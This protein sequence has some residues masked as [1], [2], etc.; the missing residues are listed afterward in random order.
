M[1]NHVATDARDRY[2]VPGLVPGGRAG[3]EGGIRMIRHDSHWDGR[4]S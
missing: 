4:G 2:N 3:N 1:S